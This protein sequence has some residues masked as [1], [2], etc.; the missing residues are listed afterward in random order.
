MTPELTHLISIVDEAGRNALEMKS[1]RVVEFKGD[2]SH[3][4]N[5][6]RETELWLKARLLPDWKGTTMW[7]EEFGF[8]P[9][10]E[11]GLWL[12]DPIDGTSNFAHGLPLWGISVALMD[13][14]GL[15]LGVIVLPEL[16]VTL[17]AE[18]GGG[19][20]WNGE[21]MPKIAAGEIAVSD[22]VSVNETLAKQKEYALLGKYRLSGAFVIDGAFTVKQY[23]RALYG[24][25]EK[26]YDIAASVLAA[27]EL[28]AEIKFLDGSDFNELDWAQDVNIRKPWGMFPAGSKLLRS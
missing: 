12:I 19:A 7:G 20:F 8:E 2:G 22:L 5:V 6:D 27:R 23:Y 4:T 24:V 15:Q 11:K 28:G 25:N 9:M 3:V 1:G 18:R 14:T 16:G 13:H 21:P 17:S 10:G 26:L